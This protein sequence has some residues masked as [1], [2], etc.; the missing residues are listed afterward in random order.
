MHALQT[1]ATT[2]DA[3]DGSTSKRTAGPPSHQ[4]AVIDGGCGGR[5]CCA[6]CCRPGAGDA[7]PAEAMEARPIGGVARAS[8]GVIPAATGRPPSPPNSH[9]RPASGSTARSQTPTAPVLPSASDT[10]HEV[11]APGGTG[12]HGRSGDARA[13]IRKRRST[14]RDVTLSRPHT[15]TERASSGQARQRTPATQGESASG[16]RKRSRPTRLARPKTHTW[17]VVDGARPSRAAL[18]PPRPTRA[19]VARDSSAE[20]PYRTRRSPSSSPASSAPPA[21]NSAERGPVAMTSRRRDDM[22]LTFV[23]KKRRGRYFFSR[24]PCSRLASRGRHRSAWP[25]RESSSRRGGS[26]RRP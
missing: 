8:G 11:A 14:H 1:A 16:V 15:R 5:V 21:T 24:E 22:E 19:S 23:W 10:R 9:T 6:C 18:L 12:D 2:D 17:C 20:T 7:G 3:T 25:A 13:S 4:V 26:T